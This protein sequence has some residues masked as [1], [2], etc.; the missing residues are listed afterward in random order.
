MPTQVFN[1][2][3]TFALQGSP[4][5]RIMED[6]DGIWWTAV[7]LAG[8]TGNGQ[9]YF[10]YSRNAGT[11][12]NWSPSSSLAQGQDKALPSVYIDQDGYAH[13]SWI[14]YDLD[15]QVVMYA[16]G[17]PTKAPNNPISASGLTQAQ[18]NAGQYIPGW[19]WKTISITPASARVAL[20]SDVV[21]FRNGT[22]WVAFLVYSQ[23]NTGGA[24][25]ARINISAKGALSV[26]ATTMGPSLGVEA[27]QFGTI[28]FA[29]TGD[30]KTPSATPHLFL[31]TA[32]VGATAGVRIARATYSG[33][34]WTW[35]TPVSLA[36]G[37][38]AKTTTCG[39][40]DGSRYMFAW[41]ANAASISCVEWD[42]V[43]AT[44][45]RSPPAL[46]GGT[47]V[48][49]GLTLAHDPV[50]H[51]IYLAFHDVTDGDVRWSKFTRAT[52]TW[53][54]WTTIIARA[55]STT[56]GQVSLPRHIQRNQIPMLYTIISGGNYT[57]FSTLLATL[58]RTPSAPTLLSPAS[59]AKLNLS[60][61]GTFSWLYNPIAPGDIEQGYI[62]KRVQG[63]TTDYW[64]A[65]TQ[66]FQ[67]GT[68]TN[69]T[70]PD[71][72]SQV[73]FPPAK[74]TNGLTYTWS[75][76]VVSSGG[77]TSAF[78][79]VRTISSAAS[80]VVVV[81]APT[82]VV[83]EDSTPLVEW[84]Y[85]SLDAQRDFEIRIVP[86]GPGISPTDP[87]GYVWTSGVTSSSVARSA[88]VEFPLSNGVGYRAY[89]RATS[90]AAITSDWV[91]SPFS[92][93]VTPPSGP[94]VEVVDSID[95]TSGV[96][97]VRMD[98]LGQSSFLTADQ[99]GSST[100]WEVDANATLSNQ[101]E[102]PGNLLAGFFM[103][104]VAAGAMSIR[105]A[106]GDPP[107][108]TVD[109]PAPV[110]PLSF[111]VEAGTAYTLM[112]S[113]RAA[114]TTRACRVKIRWYDDDDGTG[115]LISETPSLQSNVTSSGYVP[116]SVSAV[117]PSGAV[118]ARVVVETLATAA[119]GEIFYVGQV[120]FHPGRVVAYQP[121]GFS[122]RQTLRV[123]RSDDGG[124]TFNTIIVRVKPTLRQSVIAYDRLMAFGRDV[125]YRA[126][127]DIDQGFGSLLSSAVSSEATINLD[128][129][130][131]AV[132]DVDAADEAE[133]YAYVVGH[134]RSDDEASSVHRPAGRFYP[135]VDTEGMQAATGTLT[136][137]VPQ[138]DIEYATNVLARTST[139]VIQS[140]TGTTFFARLIRRAY[141]VEMLRHRQIVVPYVE[142]D[143]KLGA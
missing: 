20:D 32:P 90:V 34:V 72:P 140:P 25:V 139:F 141:N 9:T 79:A 77:S 132:R 82:N 22:G 35:G 62:F 36:T 45:T 113:F 136:I 63:V 19:S 137:F 116:I 6:K 8:S 50:T 4:D 128:A 93:F 73:T 33:G 42:G 114:A 31:G 67:S 16:R 98:L 66:A 46:P 39:V 133:L 115:V 122:T 121:G 10:Y 80:P 75:V 99:D 21:A 17:T 143:P 101:V 47:G 3:S 24:Q 124:V 76:A 49:A 125:I 74:W 100:G 123:E 37:L 111:P 94:L 107:E 59:G 84:T 70:D 14:K 54:A 109:Q 134:D 44:V 5:K 118:L 110:R 53:S 1:G 48:V 7:T 43:G 12:W 126:Y 95:Y 83:Y 89:V 138:A 15:P 18:I 103:T 117:A 51:D 78:T 127:T 81:T 91:Y 96:P 71:N 88:R 30:G 57:V 102:D 92:I 105:T 61:G 142:V 55:P 23:G 52:T 2:N 60:L 97:R 64:N 131:W 112:A 40:W 135:I 86:E 68:V 27:T 120:S 129:D 85:T 87:L 11:T 58:T 69:T 130:R 26:G 119:A 28:E 29:H 104:S 56:D 13:M 106:V 65:T 108:A 38:V 41:S